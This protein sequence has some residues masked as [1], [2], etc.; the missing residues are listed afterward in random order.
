MWD[1]GRRPSVKGQV[2]VTNQP[3]PKAHTASHPPTRRRGSTHGIGP[4]KHTTRKA[5]HAQHAGRAALRKARQP[6]SAQPTGVKPSAGQKQTYT[7]PFPH[8]LTNPLKQTHGP[9]TCLASLLVGHKG[10]G[11]RASSKACP[12]P[13]SGPTAVA[14][15]RPAMNNPQPLLQ[16]SARRSRQQATC[17]GSLLA[18]AAAPGMLACPSWRRLLAAVCH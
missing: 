3:P 18:C 8:P 13:P 10:G 14:A 4:A 2:R 9:V 6:D 7:L 15:M 1:S 12:L 5:E 16:H 11:R 17:A